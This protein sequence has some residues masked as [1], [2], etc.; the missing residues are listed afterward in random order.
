MPSPMI[1]AVLN[2]VLEQHQR[3]PGKVSMTLY[4]KGKVILAG[5]V[6]QVET[7]HTFVRRLQ[8]ADENRVRQAKKFQEL[9]RELSPDNYLREVNSV[10]L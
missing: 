7:T 5:S 2:S 4:P 3:F 8:A 9:F 6:L 10:K 1:R